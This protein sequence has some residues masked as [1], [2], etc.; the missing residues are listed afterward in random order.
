MAKASGDNP[1]V[2]RSWGRGVVGSWGR[3]VVRSRGREVVGYGLGTP[4]RKARGPVC[5]AVRV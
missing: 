2:V 3:G 4:I 1:A 5:C